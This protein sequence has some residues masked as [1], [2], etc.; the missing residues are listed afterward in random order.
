MKKIL[1]KWLPLVLVLIFTTLT[2]KPL[3][4][5]RLLF[6]DDAKL[7]AARLANYYLALKQGQFPPRWA[8]NL[9][10][11]YGYPAFNFTYPLPY[12]LGSL[13]Y[14]LFPTQIVA[15]LNLTVVGLVWWGMIGI[16]FWSQHFK[17][18]SR[19]SALIALFYFS[20]PYT[21][22]NIFSRFALGEIAF[23]AFCPWLM[24][25]METYLKQLTEEPS[26]KSS[27]SRINWKLKL[28]ILLNLSLFLLSHQTSI[29]V[30][31]PILSG[32][33]FL[34]LLTLS[35]DHKLQTYLALL[36]K[37]W[38]PIVSGTLLVMWYWLPAIL[39]KKWVV[40]GQ[41]DAISHYLTQFPARISFFVHSWQN[42]P[43]I[44][45]SQL[46]TLG[47]HFWLVSIMSIYLIF[48][49]WQKK[50]K[51]IKKRLFYLFWVNLIAIG[52]MMPFA[53]PLW[54]ASGLGVYIQY[55]WRFLSLITYINILLLSESLTQLKP[56]FKKLLLILLVLIGGAT[57][58]L[59]SQ[60]RGFQDWNDYQ[61][62]EFYH[63]TTTFNE[64][65]PQ[66]AKSNHHPPQKLNFKAPQSK[67]YQGD[68]V[69]PLSGIK[70]KIDTWSGSSMTYSLTTDKP[71]RVVQKTLYFP[72]WR[73]T[74]NQK[75]KKIDFQEAEFPGFITYTLK[76]G[77]HYIQL[78]FTQQTLAR[79]WGHGLS[80][81]GLVL[82]IGWLFTVNGKLC[83]DEN[84]L[85]NKDAT[86]T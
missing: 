75:P 46:V 60:P 27:S 45:T 58:I 86:S 22:I 55:P 64:F 19:E 5:Q 37:A 49:H 70:Q 77:T 41:V 23:F 54:L 14:M 39:E 6:A 15:S 11:G 28:L 29:L 52:L 44:D 7:H 53:R 79:R 4:S 56:K 62:F 81:L 73:L 59:F 80:L 9:N 33:Y 69:K 24:W 1:Q 38:L 72:G 65:Q 84:Q 48:N 21:L 31:V 26:L 40:L 17:L 50:G 12:F 3:I 71:V 16:Y 36:K 20:T 85:Q 51:A 32:Y 34:R 76:P 47:Y 74:I 63:T 10:H 25:I 30:V 67:L 42:L 43:R 83:Y 61:L 68:K 8:P 35:H 82:S 78:K 2:L 13:V 57:S 66:W 18:K